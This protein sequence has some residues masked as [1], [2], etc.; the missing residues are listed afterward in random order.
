MSTPETTRRRWPRALLR[1]TVVVAAAAAAATSPHALVALLLPATSPFLVLGGAIAVRT[2]PLALVLAIPVA[3]LVLRRGRWFC[4]NLCPTGHLLDQ[5]AR[6]RPSAR[7]RY[8]RF[9][10]LGRWIVLATLGGALLGWP[11]FLWLDP[12]SLFNAFFSA[13]GSAALAAA[14]RPPGLALPAGLAAVSGALLPVL[15]VLSACRPNLWCQRL[16][17]LGASQDLLAGLRRARVGAAT[18]AAKPALEKSISM[19]GRRDFLRGLA[20]IAAGAAAAGTVRVLSPFAAPS[21]M[22]IRPPGSVP[23]PRMS[24]TCARCGNCLRACPEGVIH[25]ALLDAGPLDLWTPVLRFGPSYCSEAC[26]ACNHVC[27]T[28][29][30]ATMGPEEKLRVAVGFAVVDEDTCIAFAEGRECMV[31][32][33]YCPF[34]AIEIVARDGEAGPVVDEDLCRGCG[35]CEIVCP[36]APAAIVVE[37]RPQRLLDP[38]DL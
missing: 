17:P 12:L 22:P 33:E 9:P 37:G 34:R 27:P 14:G 30:I 28:G 20:G 11:V 35:L 15:L 31:C 8:R 29:A 25:P 7:T 23:E 24:A 38:I 3:V 6:L 18:T 26:H 5:A 1:W 19:P 13:W 32:E 36:T 10:S 21:R 2:L 16:C 4:R